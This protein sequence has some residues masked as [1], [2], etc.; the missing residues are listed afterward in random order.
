M[1]KAK[2]KKINCICILGFSCVIFIF[3]LMRLL[4]INDLASLYIFSAFFLFIIY[5][6]KLPLW[7][8]FFLI[9]TYI[10]RVLYSFYNFDNNIVKFPDTIHYINIIQEMNQFD[11]ITFE[12]ITNITGT[13]HIGYNIVSYFSFKIFGTIYSLYLL[14][15]LM[16]CSSVVLFHEHLVTRFGNKIA[17]GAITLMILSMNMFIFTSNILKDSLVLF[18]TI[19]CITLYDRFKTDKKFT[20]LGFTALCSM[21]LVMT[22]IYAGFGVI[23]GIILDYVFCYKN[24]NTNKRVKLT[25]IIMILFCGGFMATNGNQYYIMA[26]N[27]IKK[28]G[29]SLLIIKNITLYAISMLFSP[30]PWNMTNEITVY[31]PTIIDS[32]FFITFSPVIIMFIFK[33]YKS[34][35]LRSKFLLYSMPILFHIIAL[36]SSYQTGAIR[37]R[38][39]VLPFFILTYIIGIYELKYSTRTNIY[40]YKCDINIKRS[41]L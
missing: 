38:I 15:I 6:S 32:T 5:K 10:I 13:L 18:L 41:Y 27:Y 2:N 35:F 39:A 24:K 17:D 33:I 7:L 3:A 19:F 36:G 29:I 4:G 9:M 37:Q 25:F 20:V 12:N 26:V 31:T 34:K 40:K 23:A 8:K 11:K 22:R 14:N 21:L 28:I 30:L 1:I 16:F